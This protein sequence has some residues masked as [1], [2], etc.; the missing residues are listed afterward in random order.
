MKMISSNRN[1]LVNVLRQFRPRSLRKNGHEIIPPI[2]R[3]IAIETRENDRPAVANDH[4]IALGRPVVVNDR[5]I[6]LDRLIIGIDREIVIVR[7]TVIMAVLMPKT[8]TDVLATDL[9]YIANIREEVRK[10]V[11]TRQN[12]P[13]EVRKENRQSGV[14][15]GTIWAKISS[16]EGSRHSIHGSSI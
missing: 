3:H 13:E 4:E 8:I 15:G 6:I 12:A 1:R 7:L 9:Q 16:V 14:G 11:G 10:I 2:D 5:E